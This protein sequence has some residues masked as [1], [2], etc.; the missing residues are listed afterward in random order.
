MTCFTLRYLPLCSM[1]S[2]LR[3][4]SFRSSLYALRWDI[5][6]LTAILNVV[7]GVPWGVYLNLGISGKIAYQDY[8]VTLL[9]NPYCLIFHN[10][11]V[12]F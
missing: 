3:S 6:L 11:K 2:A 8:L 7:T 1:L 9:I 5:L 12:F 4:F 10:N